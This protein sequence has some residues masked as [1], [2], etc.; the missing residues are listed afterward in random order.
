MERLDWG[1]AAVFVYGTLKRGQVRERCWPRKPLDVAP[2]TVGGR[3]YDLGPY[4]A[5]ASGSDRVTGEL[6]RF[7]AE[8]IVATLAALDEIEDYRGGPE[9]L[10]RRA[11]IECESATGRARAW[12]YLYAKASELREEQRIALDANDVC[13]WPAVKTPVL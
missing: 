9:D 6:W 4:P 2:A 10:Y 3:L 11:I 13:G 8:D 5:L 7:A 1:V 12:T